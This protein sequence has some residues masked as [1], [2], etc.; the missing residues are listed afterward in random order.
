VALA[1][2]VLA[3]LRGYLRRR[4]RRAIAGPAP[5]WR[6]TQETDLAAGPRRG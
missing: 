5:P 3:L 1:L 4:A 6:E 2:A